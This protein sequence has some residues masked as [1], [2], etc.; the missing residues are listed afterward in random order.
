[1]RT[2]PCL[3]RLLGLSLVLIFIILT[4]VS[5]WLYDFGSVVFDLEERADLTVKVLIK[6]DLIPAFIASQTAEILGENPRAE[7][8]ES[9]QSD[10]SAVFNFLGEEDWEQIQFEMLPVSIYQPWVFEASDSVENWLSNSQPYP[11]IVL[12][13]DQFKERWNTAHGQNTVDVIFNALPPCTAQDVEDFFRRN[14]TES[15]GLSMALNMCRLPSP[16]DELQY[17]IYQRSIS[18]VVSNLP[19]DVQVLSEEEMEQI[20]SEKKAFQ[21]KNRL[22]I[23]R[24]FSLNAILLPGFVLLL[25]TIIA[26]RSIHTWSIWW[27]IPL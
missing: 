24:V 19:D 10:V 9:G 20:Y 23:L 14:E 8:Q 15:A 18:F 22:L 12:E 26:V 4:P 7:D 1:M 27:G 13:T 11:E 16:F 2:Q 17:Q 21:L 3:S 6:T 25:I 5:L